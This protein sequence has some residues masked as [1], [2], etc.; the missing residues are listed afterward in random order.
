MV[1]HWKLS[2]LAGMLMLPPGAPHPGMIQQTMMQ[3]QGQ[4]VPP[5]HHSQMQVHQFT[6]HQ[7]PQSKL[8]FNN[9]EGCIFNTK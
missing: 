3:G 1:T 4:G 9:L 6:M 8:C 7:H 5:P 2:S